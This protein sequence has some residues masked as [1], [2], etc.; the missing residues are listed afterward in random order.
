LF[1]GFFVID[2]PWLLVS[3]GY[4]G[5]L[6]AGFAAGLVLA[7]LFLGKAHFR[8]PVSGCCIIMGAFSLP[9]KPVLPPRPPAILNAG[10]FEAESLESGMV[11]LGLLA[12]GC[13]LDKLGT[14][15]GLLVKFVCCRIGSKTRAETGGA[16]LLIGGW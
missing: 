1:K 12:G 2:P 3:S 15:A 5:R 10:H 4:R 13:G 11:D 16:G 9:G 6:L 14:E 7:L 8:V